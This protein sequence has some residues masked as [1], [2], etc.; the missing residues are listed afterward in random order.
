[1]THSSVFRY[2]LL[3]PMLAGL[4]L[5][6]SVDAAVYRVGTGSGCTHSSIQAAVDAAHAPS[7]DS[8]T[9]RITDS[10]AYRQQHVLIRGK[11]TWLTLEGGYANCQ[12][13]A[14][15]GT[16]A[17]I[18][19]AGGLAA[20]VLVIE[21]SDVTLQNLNIIGGDS[22]DFGG[23]I[24]I[25]GI[26]RTR[27]GLVNTRVGQNNALDGGGVAVLGAQ[28]LVHLDTDSTV[29]VNNARRDGGGIY[30]RQGTVQ[31]GGQRSRVVGNSAVKGGGI[32]GDRCF[33]RAATSSRYGD[34]GTI[35]SNYA[36]S[37]GGGMSLVNNSDLL[38]W[39]V[40]G[41]LPI[42]L[43]GNV[44]DG[45]GGA[46]HVVDSRVELMEAVVDGNRAQLGGGAVYV[47]ARVL[48]GAMFDMNRRASIATRCA[49]PLNCNR[50][51]NNTAR[52]SNG[53]DSHGAALMVVAQGDEAS[54]VDVNLQHV[55]ISG[56]QGYT[57]V[58]SQ[59]SSRADL[60]FTLNGSEVRGN[61]AG[62]N[63]IEFVA[64]TFS[65][66]PDRLALLIS[67]STIAGNS[68]GGSSTIYSQRNLALSHDIVWQPGRRV[69]TTSGAGID[70][71]PVEY[72]IV[73]DTTGF[74]V[75]PTVLVANPRFV[76]AAAGNLRL[77]SDSPAIDFA[78]AMG[79]AA[80]DGTTRS[81]DLRWAWNRFGAQD[82]GAFERA[83]DSGPF[84]C[85]AFAGGD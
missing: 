75:S 64:P 40:D 59:S 60:L 78:P 44:T 5:A 63:L 16:R 38:M 47:E 76:D 73:S 31:L 65:A 41:L 57:L 72:A 52:M 2:P 82:L 28:A 32:A 74:G 25:A 7:S 3:M 46:L 42:G 35:Y 79:S 56:N 34:G 30:C 55:T 77:I 6:A 50:L 19:G 37:T 58:R 15:S 22:N 69:L 36:S 33:I 84:I 51:T 20:S 13:I 62:G 67:A 66:H 80:R 9:I 70:A 10:L 81:I 29:E 53:I 12:S 8:D 11:A 45:F 48:G 18:D 43:K 85:C 83:T 14:S 54:D 24:V 23:G 49:A 68:I 27:V 26:G 61:T 71:V 17:L 4:S 1:M 39:T 21:D